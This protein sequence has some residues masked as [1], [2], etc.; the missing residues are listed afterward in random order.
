VVP[1]DASAIRIGWFDNHSGLRFT[2]SEGNRVAKR[3][4]D[5][6]AAY[7]SASPRVTSDPDGLLAGSRSTLEHRNRDEDHSEPS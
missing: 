1:P 5:L 3:T 6:P 4:H 2:L 7:P